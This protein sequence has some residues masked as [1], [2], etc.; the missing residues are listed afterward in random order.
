MENVGKGSRDLAAQTQSIVSI[1]THPSP[2]TASHQPYPPHTPSPPTRDRQK[3]KF[4]HSALCHILRGLSGARFPDRTTC[5]TG[6]ND[7]IPPGCHRQKAQRL[8]HMAVS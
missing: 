1:P 3:V 7:L 2:W 8:G 5:Q 6:Y 4:W